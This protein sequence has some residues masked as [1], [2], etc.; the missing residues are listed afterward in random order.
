[1]N[2][3]SGAFLD[4]PDA[5][6]ALPQLLLDAGLEVELISPEAGTLPERIELACALA[7]DMLV[8]AGGDGT[9]A[10]AAQRIAGTGIVLGILPF[11]TAN[12]LARDLG[13]PI[14]NVAAAVATLR[15]G[16]VRE[17]DAAEVNGQ[18]YLCGSMLGLPARLARYREMGRGKGSM[19]RLWLRFARAAFRAFARYG[20]PRVVLT[21]DGRPLELHAGAIMVTP[22]LLD[23][24]TGHRLGRD[25]LDDG[26]LGLYALKQV[27]LG[28]ILRLLTRLVLRSSRRD[29]DLHGESAR[30]IV[31][32]R[33]GRRA[34]RT[35]RVMNDGEVSLMAPPL[36]YRIVPHAIRVIVP[37]EGE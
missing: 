2:F 23:D 4:S 1:L 12:V 22:N 18:L 29:P 15:D 5:S 33:M 3:K 31:V 21:V 20:A 37:A 9:I 16:R 36:T 8:V 35:I 26:R 14:G 10:C 28:A 13:I 6:E 24:R 34:A 25:R 27:D 11:G 30:E 32:T 19:T 17:I 7:P